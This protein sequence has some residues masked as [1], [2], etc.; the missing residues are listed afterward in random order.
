MTKAFKFSGRIA[1][2]DLRHS[3]RETAPD[4]ALI[5]PSYVSTTWGSVPQYAPTV[6]DSN[7]GYDPA[8]DCQGYFM[9]VKYQPN[10]NCYAYGCN[11][12]SNS[13]P[14][15][16]RASGAPTLAN[17]FT[18]DHV[19]SNAVSDGLVFVGTT[20]EAL[21]AHAA[22]AD[23]GAGHYVALMFSEPENNI[24]G[25][26][27]AN[28][29]G[30]YHWARCDTL[31]PMSWSQKDGGDQVT[32]F[33]FA[34]NLITD[35]STANWR[36]NQGPISSSDQNEYVVSYDFYCFMYVPSSGVTIV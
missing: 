8:G 30:D 17:N 11:I 19:L 2:G 12:A 32:N 21:L 35:P 15:P 20:M 3:T 31:T 25:D 36:V 13:F 5:A 6:S 4:G 10:N 23:P 33:D 1:E 7:E 29:P 24:G 14:Q 26:S 34:G 27:N 22:E 28:W 16:G 18:A 9:S